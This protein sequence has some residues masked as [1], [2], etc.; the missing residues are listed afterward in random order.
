MTI[1]RGMWILE[2]LVCIHIVTVVAEETSVV[3]IIVAV[4]HIEKRKL[5]EK[6]IVT[7]ISSL[8]NLLF[9]LHLQF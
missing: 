5:K 3:Q 2:E 8:E 9:R 7:Y 1:M 4:S 6:Q